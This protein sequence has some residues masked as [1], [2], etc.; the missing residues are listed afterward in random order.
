MRSAAARA[1]KRATNVSLNAALLDEAKQLGINV[2]Q[3]CEQGLAKEIAEARAQRWLD[4]N[5]EAL[6]SSNAYVERHGL[7]LG[8]YR[9]F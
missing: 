5:A 3:A 6:D 1:A 2:S 9:Q 4:A 7:P 8:E